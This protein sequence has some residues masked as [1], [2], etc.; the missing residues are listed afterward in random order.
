MAT[1]KK[2]SEENLFLMDYVAILLNSFNHWTGKNLIESEASI[3]P[4]Q[5]ALQLFYAPFA[6]VSHDTA[7]DPVFNYANQTALTLFGMSWEEFTAMP[8]RFSAEPANRTE[9]A[10]LLAEVTVKGYS[11]DY[12]GIRIA[13]DGKRFCIKNAVIWNL[14]D[15]DGFNCGQAAMFNQWD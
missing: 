13:K 14:L 5:A 4:I 3:S 15:D 10:R 7:E 2:P 8:S 9:R 11:D 6:V 12:Q 1:V